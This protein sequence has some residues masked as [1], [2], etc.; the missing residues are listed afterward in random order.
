MKKGQL[1]L[2]IALMCGTA[3]AAPLNAPTLLKPD[4]GVNLELR[5]AA[6][7]TW[8]KVTNATKYRILFSTD[9]SF[10]NYDSAKLKCK[11]T[12]DCFMYT[13]VSPSYSLVSSQKLLSKNGSYFWAVQAVAKLRTND[14]KFSEIRSFNVGTPMPLNTIPPSIVRLD[15]TP[16]SVQTGDP[17]TIKATL[18][19]PILSD[20][21]TIQLTLNGE[22]QT[23]TNSGN[24]YSFVYEPTEAG[25]HQFQIDILDKNNDLIDS[26]GDSFIVTPAPTVETFVSGDRTFSY[27]KIANDGSILPIT[28]KFGTGAKDWA[29]TKDN[30]TGLIWQT[31][32]SSDMYNWNDAQQIVPA[33][34]NY[35]GLCGHKDWRLPTQDEFQNLVLCA[36][37][38]YSPPNNIGRICTNFFDVPSPTIITTYFPNTANFPYWSSMELAANVGMYTAFNNGS[39]G[40]SSKYSTYYVRL[41]RGE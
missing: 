9:K 35:Q 38:Q 12:T 21:Y 8:S 11:T 25:E 37:G 16:Q 14:G 23:L 24:D 4:K 15:A 2:I 31:Q 20:F 39:W 40:A 34:V 5:K 27:S 30:N 28:A 41:V 7:F 19:N 36:D 32:T 29:C 22:P 18:D 13:T 1:S 10:K 3:H 6:K 33:N 26:A 17:V